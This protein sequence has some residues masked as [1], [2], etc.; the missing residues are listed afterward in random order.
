MSY[1]PYLRQQN[2]DGMISAIDE[3][4][5]VTLAGYKMQVQYRPRVEDL[6]IPETKKCPTCRS[7]G[8]VFRK[9]E[10]R[11]VMCLT[12]AGRGYVLACEDGAR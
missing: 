8:E 3:I 7:R 6:G 9:H 2:L 1:L 4:V 11:W 12:C 10:K 5:L